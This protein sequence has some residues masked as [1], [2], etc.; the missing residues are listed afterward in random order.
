M[1]RITGSLNRLYAK[2]VD[3]TDVDEA[4]EIEEFAGNGVVILVC[5]LDDL[6]DIGL[7]ADVVEVVVIEDED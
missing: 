2:E 3:I 7:S 1:Y 6:G 5:N 4:R